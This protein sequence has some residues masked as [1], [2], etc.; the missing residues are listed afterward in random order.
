L[1]DLKLKL[2][3]YGEKRYL[4]GAAQL[5]NNANNCVKREFVN[6]LVGNDINFDG[7]YGE[8][9]DFGMSLSKI[10]VVVLQNPFST[11]LHLKPPV[12][13]YRFWGNQA[14][15]LGKKRKK[16][17]WELDTPVKWVRPIPSPTIMYYNYK[18]FG[19][20]LVNEYRHKYFF[21][22][23]FKGSIWSIPLRFIKM[24]YRQIQFN[25]SIFYAKKL[26][27]LGKRTK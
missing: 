12:G 25:K 27:S 14:M 21:L 4:A 20:E 16:Q 8:D 7:G 1:E 6:Q 19:P 2:A 18:H 15:V 26:L 23:L 10:G 5:F 9:N 11:N 3:N 13:G 17:P 24:F 22:F